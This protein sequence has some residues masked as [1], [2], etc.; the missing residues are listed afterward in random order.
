MT[1]QNIQ[2]EES[3]AAAGTAA[4][5]ASAE[6][7]QEFAQL[8]GEREAFY[9]M[10][11]RLFLKPLTAE[12]IEQLTAMDFVTRAQAFD[13]GLL[14]DGF[15]DM[16]RGLRRQHTGTK[17]LLSTDFT[18]CFDG[19]RSIDGKNAVPYASVF[20]SE[21]G[22][23]YREPRFRALALYRDAGVE[24]KSGVDLPEDH[25]SFEFE[26][27]A[28]LA[29]RAKEA[30]EHNNG[31]EACKAVETSR[32]FIENEMLEWTGL[33]FAR[34]AKLLETRFYQG[35]IKVAQGYLELDDQ[36]LGDVLQVCHE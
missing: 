10:L 30:F 2:K 1:V 19:V 33:F 11:S 21:D 9:R 22:L 20:L 16:G 4:C 18:M 24:L 13:E 7:M 29:G 14:R 31:E 5:Q 23:M 36:V 32:K 34:A 17:T 26:F 6:Q 3:Q 25:I 28:I 35:V 8:M 15:N 27:L 12:D